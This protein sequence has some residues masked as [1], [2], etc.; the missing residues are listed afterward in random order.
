MSFL[1]PKSLVLIVLFNSLIMVTC[2]TMTAACLSGLIL[3]S[4]MCTVI[5]LC[6]KYNRDPDN[7]APAIASC[8]GDLFTLVLLG[9]VSTLL[10]PFIRTPIPFIVGTLVVCLALICLIYTLRNEHVRPLLKE[11]WSPL[12]IAMVISSGTGIVLD[13]FVS[14][15]EGFALLAVVISGSYSLF[16]LLSLLIYSSVRFTR[17]SRLNSYFSLIYRSSCCRTVTPT[18]P[19]LKTPRTW[20]VPYDPDTPRDYPPHRIHLPRHSPQFRVARTPILIRR[21]FNIVLLLRREKY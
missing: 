11:G 16:L 19:S 6:R 12:F 7:I 9:T 2:S 17:S 1:N 5:V 15:Y 13:M 20:S 3:G 18:S 4:L 21:I 14:R 10:V 8:L